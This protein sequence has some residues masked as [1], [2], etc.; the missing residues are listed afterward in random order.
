ML[1]LQ[2]KYQVLDEESQS[3]KLAY[4]KL[5]TK[6]NE[7][8][9]S[10]REKLTVAKNNERELT[11]LVNKILDEVKNSVSAEVHNLLL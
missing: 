3:L 11:T 5:E 4:T 9:R 1:K 8:E 2:R 10:L 7:T 6:L